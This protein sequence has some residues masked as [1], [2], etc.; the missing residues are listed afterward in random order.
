[1]GE[2]ARRIEVRNRSRYEIRLVYRSFWKVWLTITEL[3]YD[4]SKVR[5]HGPRSVRL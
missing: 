1:M 4:C 5:V 3:L 2:V